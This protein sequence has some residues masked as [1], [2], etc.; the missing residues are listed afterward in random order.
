MTARTLVLHVGIHKTAS[1]YIQ[2]RL[3]RN[4]PFLRAH[5]LLYPKRR[6]DHLR[7]VQALRQ[8]NMRP[9]ARLLGRAER[10][11]RTALVSAEILAL[12]L[13]QPSLRGGGS[14]LGHLL[15]F[16]KPR[17]VDLQLVA[18]VRD[19]PAYLNSRYTQL[20]KRFYF[21]IP[22]ERYLDQT[23]R[24]GG[25]SECD[26]ERLFGEALD[27]PEVRCT[28]LPF[29]SGESDPCERLLQAIGVEGADGLGPLNQRAN[30]QPGWQAVWIAQR[31]ARQLRR[32]HLEA[33][34]TSACKA[35]IREELEQLAERQGWLA[36]PFQGLS[37]AL[38]ERLEERYAASNERFA[39]RVW[40]CSWRELFPR[41]TPCPSPRGPRSSAER[42]ELLTLADQLLAA[43]LAE[44][45]H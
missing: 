2:H 15:A 9:W 40:G 37:D 25:E 17:G 39:R 19:Q 32:H 3:K 45:K 30:A 1:T 13:A 7:L 20:L 38:L 11:G 14:L 42:Q 28:F 6:R 22:F 10:Q 23:M 33:W 31:I 36:E 44:C 26:Y 43:G 34:G 5:G 18:F 12:L 41:P 24:T 21:A 16:L 4:Q 8:G 29:R 27:Q 35:M